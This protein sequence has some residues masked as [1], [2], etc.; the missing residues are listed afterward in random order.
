MPIGLGRLCRAFVSLSSLSIES[1]TLED[2][3]IVAYAC[4]ID[5]DKFV[6]HCQLYTGTVWV[7]RRFPFLLSFSIFEDPHIVLPQSDASIQ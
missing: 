1:E 6:F 7:E 2:C 5:Q 4:N 3:C